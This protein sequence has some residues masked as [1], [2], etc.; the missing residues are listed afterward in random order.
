[1][2]KILGE[3]FGVTMHSPVARG[4]VREALRNQLEF[5]AK[6]QID[7]NLTEEQAFLEVADI[8]DAFFASISEEDKSNFERIHAEEA[9]VAP[10]EWYGNIGINGCID[11]SEFTEAGQ[12]G[13]L[14]GIQVIYPFARDNIRKLVQARSELM[15]S[16]ANTQG[17]SL[18][19]ASNDLSD[20]QVEFTKKFSFEDQEIFLNLMTDE[21]IAHTNA[22]NDETAIINQQTLEQEISNSNLTG[23][24]GG[25]IVFA[26]LIILFFMFK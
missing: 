2:K 16:I 20:V 13:E 26:C 23:I 17:I 21:M 8:F 22:L 3:L 19:Q 11:N 1:M 24:M 15:K 14:Y 6:L 25:V 10:K 4:E 9:R 12:A 7:Q 5:K 18:Y